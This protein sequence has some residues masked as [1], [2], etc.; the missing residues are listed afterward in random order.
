MTRRELPLSRLAAHAAATTPAD[1]ASGPLLERLY[2]EH[3]QGLYSLALALTHRPDR[4]EDAV[5]EAFAKLARRWAEPGHELPEDPVAYAFRAVRH[6]AL[7]QLRHKSRHPTWS[8]SGAEGDGDGVSVF[9]EPSPGPAQYVEDAERDQRLRAAVQ[10]LP[11]PQ[12]EAV[13]MRLYGELTFEQMAE[14]SGEPMGTVASRY[15]RA[16]KSLKAKLEDT[17]S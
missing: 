15:R 4:A 13:I 5:H 14:A 10:E 8:P 9:R 2:R 6:A 16:L 3:R 7:D 11:E 17:W 1:H 12:R